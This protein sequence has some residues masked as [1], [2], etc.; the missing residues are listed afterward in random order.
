MIDLRQPEA[1]KDRKIEKKGEI[2][3]IRKVEQ[4]HGI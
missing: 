2:K 3:E 4:Y 1:K